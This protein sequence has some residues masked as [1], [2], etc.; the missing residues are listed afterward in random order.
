MDQPYI[1]KLNN[2]KLEMNPNETYCATDKCNPL[3]ARLIILFN[4]TICPFIK[5]EFIKNQRPGQQATDPDPDQYQAKKNVE[6]ALVFYWFCC[7]IFSDNLQSYN[8]NELKWLKEKIKTIEKLTQD[9]STS[10]QIIVQ[11][12]KSVD[13]DN[14][15]NDALSKIIPQIV[16]PNVALDTDL[17]LFLLFLE[18]AAIVKNYYVAYY[19]KYLKSIVN[20]KI[21][22]ITACE[23]IK[24]RIDLYPRPVDT[25]TLNKIRE[26]I[27][28][29]SINIETIDQKI[30]GTYMFLIKNS[31]HTGFN[32]WDEI[33]RNSHLF[34]DPEILNDI[35]YK[36]QR[37][38]PEIYCNTSDT[39]SLQNSVATK[40]DAAELSQSSPVSATHNA[41]ARARAKSSPVSATH[42]A[43]ARARPPLSQKSVPTNAD[44]ATTW[45]VQGPPKNYD[46]SNKSWIGRR[47]GTKTPPNHV[48]E[49][50]N[51]LPSKNITYP[52]K[53]KMHNKSY[54]KRRAN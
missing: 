22:D 50:N 23:P 41:D 29:E 4:E 43:D 15:L 12:L 17:N 38:I 47:G 31:E 13:E 39:Q 30:Y 27:M 36:V 44:A 33:F 16:I 46:N 19:E 2:I 48:S 24:I 40:S 10:K 51:A 32:S 21:I 42:N 37:I 1:N 20:S 52:K 28:K 3:T 54:R 6:L 14:N 9:S 49:H 11:L 18:F 5:D 34:I 25:D 45:W 7:V 8:S 53:K 26:V 35:D